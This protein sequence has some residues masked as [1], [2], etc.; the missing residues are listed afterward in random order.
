MIITIVWSKKPSPTHLPQSPE[1]P[2]ECGIQLQ[3]ESDFSFWVV[4]AIFECVLSYGSFLSWVSCGQIHLRAWVNLTLGDVSRDNWNLYY[5]KMDQTVLFGPVPSRSSQT[6][7]PKLLDLFVE[8]QTGRD[9]LVSVLN[10]ERP[11]SFSIPLLPSL[12]APSHWALIY[13]GCSPLTAPNKKLT[14]ICTKRDISNTRS[15]QFSVYAT[16]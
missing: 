12:A 10:R 14:G 3:I 7:I 9:W 13:P 11:L 2:P 1:P 6:Q 15:A 16:K 5:L 8:K 4:N